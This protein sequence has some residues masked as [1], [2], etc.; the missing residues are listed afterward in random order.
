MS[1][2]SY[3]HIPM[4]RKDGNIFKYLLSRWVALK[5]F[6]RLPAL[7]QQTLLRRRIPLLVWLTRF[8]PP[9]ATRFFAVQAPLEKA[10]ENRE[11]YLT[12]VPHPTTGF[13]D[14]F[15]EWNAGLIVAR[16]LKL[17]FL[18]A[19]IGCPW[20]DELGISGRFPDA[21]EFLR[22]IRP[23][24]IHLPLVE[25]HD[26]SEAV[27]E[28]SA[29][30]ATA[31]GRSEP[32]VIFLADGQ[33]LHRQHDDAHELRAMYWGRA[34]NASVA[35][36]TNGRTIR[37]AVHV[38]R[39]DV[40][41]RTLDWRK[42]HMLE[43]P[44]FEAVLRAVV[45]GLGDRKFSVEIH[46]Q[47]EPDSLKT[48]GHFGETSFLLDRDP[49]WTFHQM[50]SADIL[51]ISPSGFSFAAGLMNH[52]LKLARYPWWHEI[53]MTKDWVRIEDPDTQKPA[54]VERVRIRFSN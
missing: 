31:I 23:K 41:L 40:T 46:S 51:V 28:I 29:L 45:E 24:I 20:D 14:R 26:R 11:I 34:G 25:W 44:W 38:R 15:S 48:L 50:A 36:P 3:E 4:V 43:I 16:R 8:S 10:A 1:K 52:G 6:L 42:R 33:N 27:E 7:Q 9:H 22:R 30:A 21:A 54:I 18:N 2:Q 32:T 49:I 47:G 17:P 37:I 39:G 19:G 5:R 35:S 13:G 12:C 53:P